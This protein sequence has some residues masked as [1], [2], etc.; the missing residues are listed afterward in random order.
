MGPGGRQVNEGGRDGPVFEPIERAAD[1]IS[2]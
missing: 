1:P 2:A